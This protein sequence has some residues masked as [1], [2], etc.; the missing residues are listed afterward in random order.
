MGA[1]QSRQ[2]T[3]VEN[4]MLNAIYDTLSEVQTVLDSN[5]GK[6]IYAD[7]LECH[8]REL[9]LRYSEFKKL[10]ISPSPHDNRPNIDRFVD[11]W[12][13]RYGDRPLCKCLDEDNTCRGINS[14]PNLSTGQISTNAVAY[15][16]QPQ[17][18]RSCDIKCLAG[19]VRKHWHKPAIKR[20]LA[21]RNIVPYNVDRQYS[22]QE[23]AFNPVK[24][25]DDI[26][27]IN[28]YCLVHEPNFHL[29]QVLQT[30]N[31]MSVQC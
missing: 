13:V 18:K 5:K 19:G 27:H 10:Y 11:N 29:T 31:D 14:D 25:L 24:L 17:Q 12:V 26:L 22:S 1:A 3:Q 6:F 20:G 30:L 28:G 8:M 9:L 15:M 16:E 2:V 23:S 7:D 4:D 21:R